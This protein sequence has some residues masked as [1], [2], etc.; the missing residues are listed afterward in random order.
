MVAKGLCVVTLS[1]SCFSLGPP[2]SKIGTAHIETLLFL[3]ASKHGGNLFVC[4]GVVLLAFVLGSNM[5][6]VGCRSFEGC[7]YAK[8]KVKTWARGALGQ[9]SASLGYMAA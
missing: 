6:S 5:T 4:M 7:L 1:V 3:F 2:K 8:V 9:M